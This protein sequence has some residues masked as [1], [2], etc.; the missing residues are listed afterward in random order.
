MINMFFV[1]FVIAVLKGKGTN[2]TFTLN[3]FVQFMSPTRHVA[4]ADMQDFTLR[5]YGGGR[6]IRVHDHDS[7]DSLVD[8]IHDMFTN[9]TSWEYN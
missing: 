8:T 7:V 5:I 4:I 9:P 6:V 2:S 1:R 3:R